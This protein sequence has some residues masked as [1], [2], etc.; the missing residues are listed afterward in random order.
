VDLDAKLDAIGAQRFRAKFHLRPGNRD[1]SIALVRGP[2]A[3][4]KHA[5]EIITK[6]LAAAQP[7]NDGRQT[8]Y[9]GHPVFVAQ[10][11]TGTCCRSCLR[12]NHGIAKDAALTE[13]QIE[14]VVDVICRWIELELRREPEQ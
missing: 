12:K 6:R 7:I 9:R 11:A 3:M 13:P 2:A 14:Y 10:H 4:R 8:P 1:R 5:R